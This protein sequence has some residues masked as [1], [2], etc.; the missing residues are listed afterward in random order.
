MGTEHPDFVRLY[1][2][3]HSPQNDGQVYKLLSRGNAGSAPPQPQPLPALVREAPAKEA[4][5]E[6]AE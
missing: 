1:N 6:A 4:A 5:L 3:V 2:Y